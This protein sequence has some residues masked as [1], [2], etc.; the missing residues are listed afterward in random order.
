[1]KA[2]T[3]R[4]T[5]ISA[6]AVLLALCCSSSVLHA[7]LWEK[8]Y[9]TATDNDSGYV[10]VPI[11]N[12]PLGAGGFLAMAVQRDGNSDPLCGILIICVGNNGAL[13]WQ[14]RYDVFGGSGYVDRGLDLIECA[15]GDI[16]V[17]GTSQDPL[18]PYNSRL[19]SEN[20]FLMR[21]SYNGYQ[22]WVRTYGGLD[23]DLGAS[24]IESA[25]GD[26]QGDLIIAGSTFSF[27]ADATNGSRDAFLIRTD[28]NGTLKWSRTYG[29]LRD[30]WF[31][32]IQETTTGALL[33]AGTTRSF[34]GAPTFHLPWLVKTT[35]TGTVTF[36][37]AYL[38][39]DAPSGA[40]LNTDI[41]A[42]DQ[43]TY[44]GTS[45]GGPNN[46]GNIV[47]TGICA[48]R[49]VN[50]ELYL[51]QV[52]ASGN[53]ISNRTYGDET[54]F[55]G[56]RN[57]EGRDIIELADG[58]LAVVG[59]FYLNGVVQYQVYAAKID[60]TTNNTL[61]MLWDRTYGG[62]GDDLGTSLVEVDNSGTW[63]VQG[64][65]FAGTYGDPSLL[66]RTQLY[67]I[68]ASINGFTGC[69]GDPLAFT[70]VPLGSATPVTP[71]SMVV[72]TQCT[73]ILDIHTLTDAAEG[74]CGP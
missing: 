1:M 34:Q 53:F 60:N 37:K 56:S 50:P 22:Q 61:T 17:V 35:A 65:M 52:D 31:T 42:L 64:F 54:G 38:V 19:K 36:S 18:N 43:C 48:A 5:A 26:N 74:V 71:E 14:R 55:S 47:M 15:N 45:V 7:Q 68:R 28:S 41:T 62:A 27:G 2:P 69:Y 63:G 57:E 51:L 13:V 20:V 70:T 12:S 4:R 40:L 33:M 32:C 25:A 72:R 16:V 49:Q 11:R 59:R 46:T 8:K 29:G 9:G 6:A 21:L 58:N 10:V 44:D 24:V 39:L 73:P 67:L 3:R 66:I 23:D 30:D